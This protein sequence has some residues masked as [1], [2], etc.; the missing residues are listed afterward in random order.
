MSIWKIW[1]QTLKGS[2]QTPLL[3][4]LFHGV[5]SVSNPQRIAT[6]GVFK[7][8]AQIKKICFKPSKDRYKHRHFAKLEVGLHGFQ[9]LKGSLQTELQL[10]IPHTLNKFQTLKGSLQ[11]IDDVKSGKETLSSFKPSKDRYKPHI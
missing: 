2:L 8:S 11:T 1:F 7:L 4:G 10:I 3:E 5:L 6:N 9:T